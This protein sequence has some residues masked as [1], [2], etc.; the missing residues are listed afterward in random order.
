M[1]YRTTYDKNQVVGEIDAGL[2]EWFRLLQMKD[3]PTV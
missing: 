1:S 2:M 3:D